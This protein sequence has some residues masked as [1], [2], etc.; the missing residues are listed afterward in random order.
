MTAGE[1]EEATVMEEKLDSEIRRHLRIARDG[2]LGELIYEPAIDGPRLPVRCPHCHR[3]LRVGQVVEGGNSVNFC[4][5]CGWGLDEGGAFDR[6][7]G[8]YGER[9]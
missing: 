4:Q 2:P 6:A 9:G 5:R 8:S 7:A 3:Q 1:S